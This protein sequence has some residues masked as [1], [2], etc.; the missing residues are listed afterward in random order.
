MQRI[1]HFV[2]SLNVLAAKEAEKIKNKTRTSTKWDETFFFVI[3]FWLIRSVHMRF[4]F[5]YFGSAVFDSLCSFISYSHLPSLATLFVLLHTP[6][7]SL[8][9]SLQAST[10]WIS[11]EPFSDLHYSHLAIVSVVCSSFFSSLHFLFTINCFFLLK[12]ISVWAR[13]R[14]WNP[15]WYTL[16]IRIPLSFERI[17]CVQRY[18][19]RI[20]LKISNVRYSLGSLPSAGT[21]DIVAPRTEMI[22]IFHLLEYNFLIFFRCYQ[23]YVRCSC[24]TFSFS[25]DINFHNSSYFCRFFFFGWLFVA[26]IFSS[27]LPSTVL[28]WCPDVRYVRIF[29][30]FA[31]NT[32]PTI[33]VVLYNRKSTL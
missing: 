22:F 21:D 14:G 17:M 31:F 27:I 29:R 33:E 24:S 5:S 28:Y 13:S 6:S 20:D 3:F 4:S 7:I 19:K 9:S 30:T 1:F 11:H 2:L 8:Y 15:W 10:L 12:F 16:R 23:M 26:A 18:E 32:D 25:F